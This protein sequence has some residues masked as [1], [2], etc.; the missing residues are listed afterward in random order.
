METCH[1]LLCGKAPVLLLHIMSLMEILGY[2]AEQEC[3]CCYSRC[4][5][6]GCVEGAHY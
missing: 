5:T 2:A 1:L 4:T 6:Y 3:P